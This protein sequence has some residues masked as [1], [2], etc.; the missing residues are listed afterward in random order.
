M[1]KFH[2]YKNIEHYLLSDRGQVRFNHIKTASGTFSG[3]FFHVGGLKS[4]S[5]DMRNNVLL[6]GVGKKH[7]GSI[8]W[9]TAKSQ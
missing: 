4:Y 7:S 5:S 8:K 2:G 3:R 1:V 6:R 9:L